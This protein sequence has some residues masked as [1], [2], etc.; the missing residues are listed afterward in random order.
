MRKIIPLLLTGILTFVAVWLFMSGWG[1][2]EVSFEQASGEDARPLDPLDHVRVRRT[3][4]GHTVTEERLA[5]EGREQPSHGE[6]VIRTETG[7]GVRP[8]GLKIVTTPPLDEF[9]ITEDGLSH[10]VVE[11]ATYQ[12]TLWGGDVIPVTRR[13]VDVKA[14][15]R[16]IVDVELVRGI[17]PRGVLKHA[18]HNRP[19]EGAV[20]D[21]GGFV[22][23][24]TD[25]AGRFE[26]DRLVP[27]TALRLIKVGHDD[28]DDQ[29][30]RDILLNDHRN[31]E[32]YLGGDEGVVIGEVVNASGRPI[33]ERFVVKVTVEPL[34]EV[35]REFE[36][37]DAS[38]FRVDNLYLGRYRVELH[39]PGGEFP[40]Q[41][42]LVQIPRDTKFVSMRFELSVGG[43]LEGRFVSVREDLIPGA[44]LE[45]RDRANQ[46]VAQCGPDADGSYRLSG[47]KPGTYHP[48]IIVGK[49]APRFL[50]SL[51]ITEGEVVLK[52]DVDILRAR[53]VERD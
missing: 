20:I 24:I 26:V 39:F 52:R 30:Y 17:R 9:A 53:L 33:P 15:H 7:G 37:V 6:L 49:N 2:D 40:T 34:W 43:T 23:A 42:E 35:R 46:V 5:A 18:L 29:V 8:A 4:D 16:T 45:L 44:R 1:D 47:L 11:P 38:T 51:E 31:L 36:V 41:R 28:F 10:E 19:I 21:F 14:G 12:L 50:P 22:R 13:G 25:A 32:L 27:K 3:P 48:C